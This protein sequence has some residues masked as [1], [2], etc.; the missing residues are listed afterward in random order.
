MLKNI[1]KRKRVTEDLYEI[2][3]FYDDNGGYAFP[4]DKDGNIFEL[5][6]IAL[7]NYKW[8]MDHPEQFK[9]WNWFFHWTQTYVEEGSG[10]CECGNRVV[11]KDQYLGA[12]EC[13]NCGR[14]YNLFGQELKHPKYWRD[15]PYDIEEDY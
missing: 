11:L 1:T 8:C 4:C 5:D 15:D 6:D 3:F 9:H 12:C 7:K 13:E 14:W 2:R 10:D